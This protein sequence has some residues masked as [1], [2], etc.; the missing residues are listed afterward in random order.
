V[1]LDKLKANGTYDKIMKKYFSYSIK[2]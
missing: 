2:V 1:A